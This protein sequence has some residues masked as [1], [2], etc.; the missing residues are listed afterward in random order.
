MKTFKSIKITRN[1][2]D[3]KVMDRLLLNN[4]KKVVTE[5][6]TDDELYMIEYTIHKYAQRGEHMNM[7]IPVSKRLSLDF[8]SFNDWKEIYMIDNFWSKASWQA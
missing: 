4:S 8:I 1:S 7:I 2:F 3:K 5:D 6:L